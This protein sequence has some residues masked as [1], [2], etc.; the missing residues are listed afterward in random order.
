MRVYKVG[1]LQGDGIGPEIMGPTISVLE[2]AAGGRAGVQLEWR[3]LPMGWEAI[4]SIGCPMP[5]STIDKL[6]DCHGWIMGPHDSASYP[7][8]IR[9]T[10]NPSGRLRKHFDLYAN[11][12][13][14][15][16]SSGVKG[17]VSDTD[18]VVVR[19]NT[20]G[21]YPDRNMLQGIGEVMP[22]DGV[23]LSAGVFTQRAA[24]RIAHVA[25]RMARQRRKHVSIIHKANVIRMGTGLFLETCREV[26]RQYPDVRVDDYHIDAMVA[27][28]VRHAPVFDIIVATNM[29]GDILSSLT[30]ELVGSLGLAGSLNAGDDHAMAQAA[31]GSAPDI[32]GQG[33]ANPVGLMHSAVML[34]EWMGD[35]YD[36]PHLLTISHIVDDA[37]IN[38]LSTG[39]LTPDLGGGSDTESFTR[40]VI[41]QLQDTDP[42]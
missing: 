20:E 3:E 31:H 36:D 12:R 19:E 39:P 32:A 14:A 26:A 18:L 16:S 30:A 28:L 7:Q 2:A 6:S 5:E 1:I 23:V 33:V 9:G 21:F 13:P 25:F 42:G 37:I 8:N 10:L 34:L 41:R 40:A 22:S 15:R 35:K 17:L 4:H 27:H 24:E 29:F 11:I 38:A